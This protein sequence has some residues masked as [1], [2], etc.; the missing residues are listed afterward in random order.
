MGKFFD[1]IKEGLE[2]AVAYEKGKRTLR[3][4]LVNLPD[5]PAIRKAK[6]IKKIRDLCQAWNFK[7]NL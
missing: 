6:D 2:D 7:N 4:H 5:P 3:S 1:D